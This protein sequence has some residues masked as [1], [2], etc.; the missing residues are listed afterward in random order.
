M[1]PSLSRVFFCL[2]L[3]L[4]V[5]AP[6]LAQAP[7][8]VTDVQMD[9]SSTLSWAATAGADDYNV[10]RGVLSWLHQGVPGKC[11]GD[12]ITA[13]SFQTQENPDVGSGF[14]YL[15]TAESTGGEGTPGNESAGPERALLG[16]CDNVVRKHLL[17][18]T[19][20]GW[21]EWTRDRLEALGL[22]GYIDEQLD[23]ASIDE[24]TNTLLNDRLAAL[25][26]PEDH[27]EIISLELVNGIY[28]RRQLEWNYAT[29]WSN[30]FN[31]D[32]RGPL[33]YFLN[34]YPDCGGPPPCDPDYPAQAYLYTA[35][36]Q[37]DEV[38]AWRDLGFN[39]NFREM[40]EASALSPAMIFYLNTDTNVAANPNENY[41]REL[42]ELYTM[43]VD[44]GYTQTDIVELARVFTGWNVCKKD[45]GAEGPLD[46][47]PLFYWQAT[48][49]YVANFGV[50][51]HDCEA[52]TLFQGTAYETI[53]PDTCDGGGLPTVDGLDDVPLALDAIV[54]HPSTPEFISTKILQ[55][56]VT[57]NPTQAMIDAVV[58]EWNDGGNPL[59]VGDMREV[60][61]AALNLVDFRDP[62]RIRDKG[63]TPVEHVVAAM[64]AT[65]GKWGTCTLACMEEGVNIDP[66]LY[67]QDM[68]HLPYLN[69]V[70]TGY[71]ELGDDWMD[72]NNM[73][74]RQNFGLDYT[75]REQLPDVPDFYAEIIPLLNDNGISTAPG[76]TE[77]IVDFFINA[78]FGGA[79]TP[80]ERQE[81]IDYLDTDDDGVPSPY[82]DA[83][84][85]ETVAFMLGLAQ[86]QEQ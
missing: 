59:G 47:C 52:K 63:R 73:L 10:Y 6:V 2:A 31:T 21:D 84:I 32:F 56:F 55:R 38:D 83:R 29:F 62:D 20:F 71:S 37:D 27:I 12:E 86:F 28:S 15:V 53:I 67:L 77:A 26:P 5:S 7:G 46:P 43:G 49:D 85:E 57:E 13:I 34:Q 69:S 14:F 39:G 11:H 25:D 36:T 82:D 74:A 81:V 60:L 42:L 79:L 64:R 19:G 51:Q 9:G 40:I 24:S 1:R 48:G 4:S 35:K 65:R 44:N 61:R 75:S 66:L 45:A 54:A 78:L 68:Q 23:P 33:E 72:T 17:S 58:A 80:V 50:N 70:P 30:H 22:Q 16:Q 8:E 41:P 76:N 18:R 3:T